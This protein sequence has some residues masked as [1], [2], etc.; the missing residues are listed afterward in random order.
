[1]NAI[2]FKQL[3]FFF[4]PKTDKTTIERNQLLFNVREGDRT[5]AMKHHRWFSTYIVFIVNLSTTINKQFNHI[6]V[7]TARSKMKS[8]PTTL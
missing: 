7:A 8:C 6:C 2:E 1:M 5:I 4:V 3:K